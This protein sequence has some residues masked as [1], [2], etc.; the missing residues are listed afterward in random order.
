MEI[1]F[2]PRCYLAI[3]SSIKAVEIITNKKQIYSICLGSPQQSNFKQIGDHKIDRKPLYLK[4]WVI[5]KT[6]FT[7]RK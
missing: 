7:L 3:R 5:L 1:G 6:G 2:V 4:K